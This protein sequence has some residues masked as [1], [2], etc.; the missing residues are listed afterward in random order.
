[1]NDLSRRSGVQVQ[2]QTNFFLLSLSLH[3]VQKA[4]SAK[5][6]T[7]Y[8]IMNRP[9]S[10]TSCNLPRA[11]I[12]SLTTWE[13]FWCARSGSFKEGGVSCEKRQFL[14]NGSILSMLGSGVTLTAPRLT[15]FWTCGEEL[16]ICINQWHCLSHLTKWPGLIRILIRDVMG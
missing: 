2:S 3:L 5:N 13:Y 7:L 8:H 9:W 16:R 11:S 10:P 4:M 15:S 1:M 6:R 12:I 14:F